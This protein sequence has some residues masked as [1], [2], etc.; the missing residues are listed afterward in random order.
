[1]RVRFCRKCGAELPP[2][3]DVC[4]KCGTPTSIRERLE[5]A[6]ESPVVT[7]YRK[8]I[9]QAAL[10]HAKPEVERRQKPIKPLE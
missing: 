2:A 10:E 7:V 3:A 1:V 8:I 9:R 6:A 5:R 4:Q